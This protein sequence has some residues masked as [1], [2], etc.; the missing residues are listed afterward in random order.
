MTISDTYLAPLLPQFK[1]V[2]SYV[3]P[4]ADSTASPTRM[5][6]MSFNWNEL[7]F[8]CILSLIDCD[9]FLE[10]N[11]AEHLSRTK[12]LLLRIIFDQIPLFLPDKVPSCT[13]L[14]M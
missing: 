13:S 4:L 8:Y 7:T 11:A 1:A 5:A 2:T 9:S 10:T 3:P 14:F 12:L 6:G